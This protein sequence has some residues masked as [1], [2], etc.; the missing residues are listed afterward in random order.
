MRV[1]RSQARALETLRDDPDASLHE[2][3]DAADLPVTQHTLATAFMWRLV[4]SG[5]LKLQIT[6]QGR[7][8]IEKARP[9]A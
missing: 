3:I 6:L 9:Q 7:A 4:D 1:T 5:Y 2:L 8:A